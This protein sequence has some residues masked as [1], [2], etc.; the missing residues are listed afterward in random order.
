VGKKLD[1]PA[2]LAGM[3]DR[4]ATGYDARPGY[5]REV[6]DILRERCGLGPGTRVLEIGPGSG[7]AT[8]PILDYGAEVTAVEP[9][10]A[11]ARL[12]VERTSGRNIDVVVSRFEAVEM[13]EANFDLIASATAFHWVD[14][15]VGLERCARYL[16]DDGWLAL[17]WTFWGD[18]DRPDRFHEALLPILRVQAPHLLAEEAGVSAYLQDV[19]ARA[20]ELEHSPAFDAVK[21][22]TFL[23]EGSHEPAALR[24]MFATFAAWIALPEP[25]RAELLDDVETLARDDFG[26]MVTRP[27]KTVLYTAR[28]RPR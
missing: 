22:D 3:F 9:G 8:M 7:Q 2:E 12:L 14:I 6:F 18:P 19:A 25:T 11:L 21:E 24:A 4:M 27:Y 10:A 1:R 17:W 28:R 13:P 15:T 16:R 23:W 26:G 5:P 20:G